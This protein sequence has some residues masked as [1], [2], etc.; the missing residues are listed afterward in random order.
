VLPKP[1]TVPLLGHI[2]TADA[3]RA[4]IIAAAARPANASPLIIVDI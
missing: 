2:V 3:G 4:D 1:P